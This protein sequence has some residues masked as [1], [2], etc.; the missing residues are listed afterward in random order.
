M[1]VVIKTK[2]IINESFSSHRKVWNTAISNFRIFQFTRNRRGTFDVG[3]GLTRF[4]SWKR[5]IPINYRK[6]AEKSLNFTP[7]HKDLK[8]E[9]ETKTCWIQ[10]PGICL[11]AIQLLFHNFFTILSCFRNASKIVKSTYEISKLLPK[12]QFSMLR[13]ARLN[14]NVIGGKESMIQQALL[15]IYVCMI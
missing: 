13:K 1:I 7:L 9:N 6:T 4:Q 2:P 11:K 5:K 15:I 8:C 14:K 12:N 10:L 3:P